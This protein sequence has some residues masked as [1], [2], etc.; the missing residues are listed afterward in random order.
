MQTVM[1]SQH[2][3]EMTVKRLLV[4]F[5]VLAVTGMQFWS[6]TPAAAQ[7]LEP[8]LDVS[9]NYVAAGA[10]I[11]VTGNQWTPFAAVNVAVE[12][13]NGNLSQLVAASG[14]GTWA[15]TFTIPDGTPPGSYRVSGQVSSFT[16]QTAEFTVVG[17][18][19]AP[20]LTTLPHTVVP[21]NE[22][23]VQGTGFT[24]F[25]AVRVALN[26]PEPVS[27]TVAANGFGS[28]SAVFYISPRTPSGI[29]Y[30]SAQVSTFTPVTI[31]FTVQNLLGAYT[32]P[33]PAPRGQNVAVL[34]NRWP[35]NTTVT[36]TGEFPQAV[37]VTART[38][39][40]GTFQANTTVPSSIPPGRYDVI[41][42]SKGRKPQDTDMWVK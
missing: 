21:G 24:S 41:I 18:P 17:G 33:N 29:Y 36:V 32:Y 40:K 35:A 12:L 20:F 1:G 28:I 26:L 4:A 9:P 31:D 2:K 10:A 8:D 27:Q 16:P 6:T 23:T 30:A 15:T 38:T 22:L 5:L 34:G 7:V 39:A 42:Q 3:G 19:R 14:F 11:T 37:S 25:A 13:P